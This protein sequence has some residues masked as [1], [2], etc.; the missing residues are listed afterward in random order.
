MAHDG[1]W[2]HT[3]NLNT[4]DDT[5]R[6][7]RRTAKERFYISEEMPGKSNAPQ[8]LLLPSGFGDRRRRSGL[9]ED[10]AQQLPCQ[11]GEFRR[12]GRAARVNHNVPS[13][14]NL[15]SVQP[16]NFPETPPDAIARHGGA[17]R[18]FDAPSEAA[19]AQTIG[20]QKDRELAARL[21]AAGAIDRV[22]IASANQAARAGEIMSR[23]FRRA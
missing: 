21:T 13:W 2:P 10:Q 23:R 14:S 20:A 12:G 15:L 11:R 7:R 18:L 9:M 17:Q 3:R 19:D 1:Q 6:R 22:V 4:R 16:N 5:C 8:E